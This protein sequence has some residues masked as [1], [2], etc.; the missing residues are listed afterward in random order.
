MNK[1][2]IQVSQR[3]QLVM[4]YAMEQA[5]TVLTLPLL[6]L[7]TWL[8]EQIESNPL[9]ILQ[10]P[11]EIFQPLNND[12][13][14]TPPQHED[15]FELHCQIPE[16]EHHIAEY[17]LFDIDD[18]GV[19]LESIKNIAAHFSTSQV[20]IRS[21]IEKIRK[22]LPSHLCSESTKE[23]LLQK[24]LSLK[25]E[26]ITLIEE[27]Y[28]DL[29]KK[30]YAAIMKRWDITF[31]TLQKIIKTLLHKQHTSSLESLTIFPDIILLEKNGSFTVD[32]RASLLPHFRFNTAYLDLAQEDRRFIR[33]FTAQAKWL[34]RIVARRHK[35]LHCTAEEIAKTQYAY[36]N[37]ETDA[38]IPLKPKEICEKLHCHESTLARALSNKHIETPLGTFPLRYFFSG[39][40]SFQIEHFL[41]EAVAKEPKDTPLSDEHLSL[42]LQ[43][44]GIN[45]ARRTI[46]KYRNILGIPRASLRRSH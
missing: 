33:R 7:R 15:L 31:E 38:I 24:L 27:S 16:E 8:T 11:E 26:Y 2:D 17:L 13:I 34:N 39:H 23:A 6:E 19:L 35:I 4:S 29:L 44:K 25:S 18:Q 28:D 20:K 1:L 22:I 3:S 45:C 43:E 21:I 30:K 12:L 32:E 9:L 46:A 37:G 36:L 14:A 41:S 10:P 40:T 42:Y 5:F